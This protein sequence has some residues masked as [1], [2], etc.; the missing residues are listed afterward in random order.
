ML[1]EER[2]RRVNERL[3]TRQ[4]RQCRPQAVFCVSA[5]DY[6]RNLRG[7]A[8]HD[9]DRLP[10]RPDNTEIPSLKRHL[11]SLCAPVRVKE[12]VLYVNSTLPSLMLS[13]RI[14]INERT[15]AFQLNIEGGAE[16]LSSVSGL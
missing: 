11:I 10:L 3:M 15:D 12:L 8:A 7:F 14:G 2:N 6:Q 16:R 13:M 1:V 5:F 4:R 9:S